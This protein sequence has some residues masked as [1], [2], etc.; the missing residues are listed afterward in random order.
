MWYNCEKLPRGSRRDGAEQCG[1]DLPY[2]AAKAVRLDAV[3]S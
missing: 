3:L 1:W 2:L